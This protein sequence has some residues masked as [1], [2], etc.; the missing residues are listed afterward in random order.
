MTKLMK[1]CEVLLGWEADLF[2]EHIMVGQIV[3]FQARRACPMVK[4]MYYVSRD[5]IM[6]PHETEL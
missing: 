5:V 1:I 3:T 2:H 4:N 6:V